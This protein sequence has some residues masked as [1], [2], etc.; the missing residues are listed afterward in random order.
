MA[1]LASAVADGDD[2]DEVREDA[3][4]E[5]WALRTHLDGK[6]PI[7]DFDAL[8]AAIGERVGAVYEIEKAAVERLSQL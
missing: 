3:A 5:L 8:F 6:P 7:D 4:T 1:T 2:G